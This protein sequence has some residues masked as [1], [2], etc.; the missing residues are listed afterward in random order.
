MES[1]KIG[2]IVIKK[3]GKPF[4]SGNREEIIKG[5]AINEQDPKRK[6]SIVLSDDSVCNID[7]IKI[8]Q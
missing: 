4:K 3:S 6:N 2:D 1:I 8:K 5:F 7:M